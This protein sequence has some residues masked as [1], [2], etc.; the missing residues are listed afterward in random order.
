MS[1]EIYFIKDRKNNY[2][3]LEKIRA[4]KEKIN[5][6]TYIIKSVERLMVFKNE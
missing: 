6:Q 4:Y 3:N 5:K 2:I 1:F